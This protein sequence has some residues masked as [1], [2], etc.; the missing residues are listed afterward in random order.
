[1]TSQKITTINTALGWSPFR[2]SCIHRARHLT[3][4]SIGAAV[5]LR[6]HKKSI[7][8]YCVADADVNLE[9]YDFNLHMIIGHC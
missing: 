3:I 5:W 9:N 8:Q 7:T 6:Q 1:M 2:M 4:D